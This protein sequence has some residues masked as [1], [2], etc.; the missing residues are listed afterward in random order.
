MCGGK[1]ARDGGR[2]LSTVAR[3]CSGPWTP[4]SAL[5][6]GEL[7]AAQQGPHEG[8]DGRGTHRGSLSSRRWD[9]AF[10]SPRGHPP[11]SRQPGRI[12]KGSSRG[13]AA[14]QPAC[15]CSGAQ[16]WFALPEAPCRPSS[17]IPLLHKGLAPSL[18]SKGLGLSIYHAPS[19][20][21]W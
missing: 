18:P 11:Q 6:G 12:A 1:P 4:G 2:N 7:M 21:S 17:W 8:R 20:L 5:H 10:R 15:G 16:A 14:P 19:L 13:R 9:L 3:C